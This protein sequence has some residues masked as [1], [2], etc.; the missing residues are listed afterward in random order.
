MKLA[1]QRSTASTVWELEMASDDAQNST[2]LTADNERLRQEL[3][4]MSEKIAPVEDRMSDRA[5]QG[6]VISGK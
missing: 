5:E 6:M 2:V 3:A 1:N 4:Q